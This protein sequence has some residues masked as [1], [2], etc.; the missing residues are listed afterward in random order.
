[1]ESRRKQKTDEQTELENILHTTGNVASYLRVV[2]LPA[3]AMTS[4]NNHDHVK[5][6]GPRQPYVKICL[7]EQNS[8]N[9]IP[10]S[11]FIQ[12][13]KHLFENIMGLFSSVVVMANRV[14]L[15]ATGVHRAHTFRCI[16]E[17]IVDIEDSTDVDTAA[18][19]TVFT[20]D[21]EFFSSSVQSLHWD[22]HRQQ[23]LQ[24]IR[25]KT[26]WFS[27][28]EE[29]EDAIYKH[30]TVRLRPHSSY[31]YTDIS[32]QKNRLWAP[33]IEIFHSFRD[34]QQI[35][36][37]DNEMDTTL[38]NANMVN[39]D[40]AGAIKTAITSALGIQK[41]WH[42]TLHG[43]VKVIPPGNHQVIPPGNGTYCQGK[44]VLA[45]GE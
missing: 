31:P 20:Y 1:M 10:P 4:T 30:W 27:T 43:S 38:R 8:G 39:K 25:G 44:A 34:E 21:K 6:Q 7:L 13:C 33:T 41:S 32:S 14:N 16:N 11:E 9:D 17:I 37:I 22:T 36:Q 45:R 3:L 18:R 29:S 26:E 12:G 28:E 23:F 35:M 5:K 24:K 42:L 19:Q 15:N 40:H 2:D